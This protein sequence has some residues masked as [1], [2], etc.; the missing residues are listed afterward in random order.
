MA[1]RVL[2][3]TATVLALGVFGVSAASAATLTVCESGPPTC[4]FSNIQSA[5]NAA[6]SGDTI[7]IAAGTYT[8]GLID[9]EKNLTLQGAGAERTIINQ[10]LVAVEPLHVDVTIAGVTI[11]NGHGV[12]NEGT[13]TLTNSVVKN[14]S[15]NGST[16]I[17]NFGGT[18]TLNSSTVTENGARHFS[19]G[20]IGNELG[21]TVTLNNSTV[22]DN[23][24]P[25]GGG[26]IANE[27]GGTVT[28]HNSTVSGNSTS[29]LPFPGTGQQSGGGIYNKSGTVTLSNTKV[30]GNTAQEKG[31]GIYNKATLTLNNST[32]TGNT[33]PEGAGIFNE[34]PGEVNLSNSKVQS[35]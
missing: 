12:F 15:T 10:G 14:N 35:P 22:T 7:E 19:G 3:A 21:G 13:L 29:V 6:S 26:G 27:E 4:G 31:G 11:A 30:S 18:V 34:P 23:H 1:K 8:D 24:A 33:A 2:M 28:L 17:D 5:V 25:R 20:G 16:G 9:I 32:I